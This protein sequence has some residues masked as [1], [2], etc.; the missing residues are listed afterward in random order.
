LCGTY[1]REERYVQGFFWGGGGNLR[2]RDLF[3]FLS[4]D[5]KITI[6]WSFRKYYEDVEWIGI[7]HVRNKWWAFVNTVINFHVL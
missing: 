2:E 3:E 6:K 4:V 5:E 1:R 7:G